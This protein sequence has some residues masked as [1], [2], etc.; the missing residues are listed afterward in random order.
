MHA[1]A[2]TT[3]KI[4]GERA[5]NPRRNAYTWHRS[6]EGCIVCSNYTSRQTP[7]HTDT[8]QHTDTHGQT[9]TRAH[10]LTSPNLTPSHQAFASTRNNSELQQ[11]PSFDARVRAFSA[12]V[13]VLDQ[14]H[15]FAS[16]LLCYMRKK[17]RSN[18]KTVCNF[19][20]LIFL[21]VFLKQGVKLQFGLTSQTQ[22]E[23]ENNFFFNV[24]RPYNREESAVLDQLE[25]NS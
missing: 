8:H 22:K 24:L 1:N 6:D 23:E 14:R 11:A 4:R 19:F 20:P 5:P 16:A 25:V 13:C 21:I 7:T 3:H 2:R 12:R 9:R 17:K 10:T 15:G 18:A